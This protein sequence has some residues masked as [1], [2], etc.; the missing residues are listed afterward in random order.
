MAKKRTFKCTLSERRRRVFN[1]VQKRAAVGIRVSEICNELKEYGSIGK[2]KEKSPNR[3]VQRDLKSFM[4]EDE[5]LIEIIEGSQPYQ[6]RLTH[7]ASAINSGGL[8]AK[9]ALAYWLAGQHLKRLLPTDVVDE[10]EP[11]MREAEKKLDTIAHP[12]HGLAAW[13]DKVRVLETGPKRQNP[14]VHQDIQAAVY[15]GLLNRYCLNIRYLAANRPNE[16]QDFDRVAPL[17]L[18]FKDGIGYLLCTLDG[19]SQVVT[20]PLHRMQRATRC[21]GTVPVIN[22]TFDIDKAIAA[23]AL[24]F[25]D[26]SKIQLKAIFS[27]TMAI[28][29]KERPLSDDQTEE[30]QPDDR[31]L[32]TATV[33]NSRELEWWLLSLGDQVEVVEPK[34]YREGIAH[35]IENLVNVYAQDA[36]KS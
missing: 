3:T 26:G 6:Y 28:H 12:T 32:V 23:G 35:I 19:E 7:Y 27:E 34:K 21:S 16:T 33:L 15:D 22:K 13:R 1:L 2:V 14:T 36:E 9:S 31:L 29:I 20:L 4:D 30:K 8:S 25:S 24:A 17:G 18:A 11:M 5:P 10:W